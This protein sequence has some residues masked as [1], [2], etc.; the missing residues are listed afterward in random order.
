MTRYLLLFDRYGL[1]LW[2]TLSDERTDLSF[3]YAAGPCQRSLSWVRVPCDFRPYFTVPDLRLP[4]SS[5]P[6]TRRVT[7]EVFDSASTGGW[8]ELNSHSRILLY[9]LGTDHTES[10]ASYIVA[11][12]VCWNVFTELLP[13]NVFIK[14]VTILKEPCYF[15]Y[16]LLLGNCML[17]HPCSRPLQRQFYTNNVRS[18]LDLPTSRLT[19]QMK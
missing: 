5:P 17:P 9:P 7:V 8:T 1:A 19:I 13:S 3:I 4:F 18:Y 14:S 2:G 11:W 6:M 16:W 12:R 15:N 10:T